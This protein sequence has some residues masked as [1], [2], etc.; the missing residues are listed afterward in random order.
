MTIQSGLIKNYFSM[1]YEYEENGLF[2]LDNV[3]FSEERLIK[4]L[5]TNSYLKKEDRDILCESLQICRV[6][7]QN[8]IR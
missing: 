5:E 8:I 6:L 4:K 7:R 2:N 3:V 1:I